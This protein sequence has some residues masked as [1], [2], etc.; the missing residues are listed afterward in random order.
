MG[1]LQFFNTGD[2]QLFRPRTASANKHQVGGGGEGAEHTRV[3]RKG[4]RAGMLLSIVYLKLFYSATIY[5]NFHV[6][7]WLWH[8]TSKV[9]N[10]CP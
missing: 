8:D 7:G 3:P 10:F 2:F 9:P 1:K 5:H 4:A 6:S